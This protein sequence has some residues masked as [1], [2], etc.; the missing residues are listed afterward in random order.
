MTEGIVHQM[1]SPITITESLANGLKDRFFSEMGSGTLRA[2]QAFFR[3]KLN[4]SS[5]NA[6][7][8]LTNQVRDSFKEYSL[9][10]YEGGTLNKPYLVFDLLTPVEDRQYNSWN[11]KCLTGVSFLFNYEPSSF[12]HCFTPYNISEHAISRLFLR[13]KPVIKNNSIDCRYITKEMVYIPFWAS[14]W[15]AVFFAKDSGKFYENATPL[16]PAP[17][18]IF[19]CDFGEA[20]M[21]PEIR[22]FVDD[23]H[24]SETQKIAKNLMIQVSQDLIS[25]PL[26]FILILGRSKLDDPELLHSLVARRIFQSVQYRAIRDSIFYRIDDDSRRAAIKNEFDSEMRKQSENVNDAVEDY[27][28][29]LG[30]RKFQVEIKRFK[31]DLAKLKG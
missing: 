2:E 12:L 10:I 4:L 21:R 27:L 8:K 9:V 5:R 22:T 24:L 14:F 13:T 28:K 29:L 23:S 7:S 15:G 19:L 3:N 18:G 26:A 16:I 11:E 6:F 31:Y 20:T 1:T 30:V 17:C 25:S